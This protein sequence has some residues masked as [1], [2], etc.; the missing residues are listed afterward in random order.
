MAEFCSFLSVIL[1]DV[2]LCTNISSVLPK[3]L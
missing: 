1:A 2:F 3:V